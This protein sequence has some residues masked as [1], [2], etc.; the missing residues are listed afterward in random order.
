MKEAFSTYLSSVKTLC[1]K[2]TD[3]ELDYL[4]SGLTVTELKPKQFYIHANTVQKEIGFVFSG[5]LRTFYIDHKGNQITVNFVR[6]N[7]YV[8][9]YPTFITQTPCKNYFQ[10]IIELLPADLQVLETRNDFLHGRIPDFNKLGI[11]REDNI[12]NKDMYYASVRL[13]TLLSML[14]LKWIGYDN[15]VL[16]YPKIHEKY[17]QIKLKEPYYR[18]V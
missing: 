9:H 5:L 11:D 14:I 4:I 17:C 7:R 18:K 10:C 8:T 2:V 12:K 6:E 3:A 15:Y 16:N 13:F 1:P